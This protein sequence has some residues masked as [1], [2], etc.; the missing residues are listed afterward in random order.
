M[1]VNPTP[2][3]NSGASHELHGRPEEHPRA[4]TEAVYLPL[5]T[6]PSLL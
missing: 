6:S 3:I 4:L 5:S 1:A 2:E